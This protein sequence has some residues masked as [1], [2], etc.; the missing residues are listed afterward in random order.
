M[1]LLITT[2]FTVRITVTFDFFFVLV[3]VSSEG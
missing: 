2:V 1:H 3:T